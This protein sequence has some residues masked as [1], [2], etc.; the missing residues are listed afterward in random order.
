MRVRY[1]PRAFAE[2]EE[3]LTYIDQRN[4]QGAQNVKR[5]IVHSIRLLADFPLM[6]PETQER[7]AYELSI[8]GCPCKIYYR[9]EGK[10]VWIVHILTECS[11]DHHGRCD[12]GPN[13]FPSCCRWIS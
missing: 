9:V 1:S 12:D 6:A 2:R 4:P 8:P 7:G 13:P 10:E 3:I 11:E 5:A